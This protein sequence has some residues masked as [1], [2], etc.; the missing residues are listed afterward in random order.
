M[1]LRIIILDK[2]KPT[3]CLNE[4]LSEVKFFTSNHRHQKSK[5]HTI[6]LEIYNKGEWDQKT[7]RKMFKN[8]NEAILS[9]RKLFYSIYSREQLHCRFIG[10]G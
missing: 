7:P 3:A 9:Q 6:S 10:K 1:P 8:M 5:Q 2:K 4:Q